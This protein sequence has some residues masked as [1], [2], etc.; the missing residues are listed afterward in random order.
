MASPSV[1]VRVDAEVKDRLSAI[2]RL[3]RRTTSDVI[4]LA[5]EHYLA[6]YEELHPQ[7]RADILA[8]LKEMREGKATPYVFG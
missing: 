8:G 4:K 3:E 1:S 7:F 2:A 5:I 6:A